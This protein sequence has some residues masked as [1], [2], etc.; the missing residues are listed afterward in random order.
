MSFSGIF[1]DNRGINKKQEYEKNRKKIM[2]W[3][4]ENPNRRLSDCAKA[5]KLSDKTIYNHVK[6]LIKNGELP[7]QK[8]EEVAEK[9]R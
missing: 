1:V 8:Q 9:G 5:L 7:I 2:E 4:K 6:I 3:I